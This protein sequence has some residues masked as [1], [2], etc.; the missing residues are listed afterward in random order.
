MSLRSV[1]ASDVVIGDPR[2]HPFHRKKLKT[3][4]V[5]ISG[6]LQ[7]SRNCLYSSPSGVLFGGLIGA[8]FYLSAFYL[9]SLYPRPR[10]TPKSLLNVP[11]SSLE[12]KALQ[13]P[14][15]IIHVLQSINHSVFYSVTYAWQS[16]KRL[17]VQLYKVYKAYNRKR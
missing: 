12:R 4:E 14:S 5:A 8:P 6:P 7:D 16:N 17:Q 13:R 9:V 3:S 1:S 2:M 15:S 11:E 10:K